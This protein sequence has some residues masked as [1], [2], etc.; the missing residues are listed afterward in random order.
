MTSFRKPTE[1]GLLDTWRSEA[2]SQGVHYAKCEAARIAYEIL[3]GRPDAWHIEK[4]I[5]RIK[6]PEEAD[7]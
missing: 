7:E 6:V 3:R 2:F 1:R 4:A 5:M